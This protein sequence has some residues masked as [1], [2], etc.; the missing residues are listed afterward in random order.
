[1]TEYEV[2]ADARFAL[3]QTS[4]TNLKRSRKGD[5]RLP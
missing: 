1:M 2:V 3:L 5:S 4:R